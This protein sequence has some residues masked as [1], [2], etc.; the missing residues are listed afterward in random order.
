MRVCVEKP[1]G[2]SQV[3]VREIAGVKKK[4]NETRKDENQERVYGVGTGC[5]K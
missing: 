1:L 5:L 4:Q 2:Y 3:R